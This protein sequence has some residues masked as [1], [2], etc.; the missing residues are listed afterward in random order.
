MEQIIV[1]FRY[2]YEFI[3]FIVT[4]LVNIVTLLISIP[5]FIVRVFG[6]LP[7]VISGSI[8]ILVIVC[9]AYKIISLGGSGE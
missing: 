9:I 4:M 8:G 3:S 5:I 1:F 2:I 7:V 6:A